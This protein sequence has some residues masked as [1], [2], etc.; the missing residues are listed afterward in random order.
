M[1]ILTRFRLTLL[2]ALAVA[3]GGLA[4]VL[5]VP[6]RSSPPPEP[7]DST[8]ASF[9]VGAL[10][11][12]SG[13]GSGCGANGDGYS[14]TR[15]SALNSVFIGALREAGLGDAWVGLEQP[16]GDK[17]DSCSVRWAGQP[18]PP[19]VA[20]SA[21]DAAWAP[22][23]NA[24][25]THTLYLVAAA[26]GTATVAHSSDNGASFAPVNLPGR[27]APATRPWIAAQGPAGTL[28]SFYDQVSAQVLVFG[29]EDGGLTYAQLSTVLTAGDQRQSPPQLGTLAIDHRNQAGT[30]PARDWAYQALLAPG[31]ARDTEVNRAFVA[32]SKDTGH[33]W[34]VRSVA[35]RYSARNLGRQVPSLSV[36]PDGSLWYA[37][38]DGIAL[39]TAVS[40]NQGASWR[41]PQSPTPGLI[42][43]AQPSLVATSAGVDMVFLGSRRPGEWS[44][45]FAQNLSGKA[46]DWLL[47]QELMS[48]HEG[49]AESLVPAAV[50]VDQQGWL[51][52]SYAVDGAEQDT[53]TAQ[54]YYAVQTGGTPA[55]H[56]N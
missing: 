29:S 12:R 47:P 11:A 1:R 53:P 21:P 13:G 16:G 14:T 52:I 34:S 7:A 22:A 5:T 40:R 41:C 28:V 23:K 39:H 44:L 38:S 42:A 20:G 24:A 25:G 9:S 54:L 43:T 18:L 27:L 30:A 31:S 56:P 55:G 45:F 6:T 36:A 15:V 10:A 48:V 19:A 26:G 8:L 50:D 35:C 51:H 3:A 33:S 49:N 37:W 2:I 17:A 4:V 46:G 32:V